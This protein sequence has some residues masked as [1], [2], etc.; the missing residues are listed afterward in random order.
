MGGVTGTVVF[1]LI[2]WTVLF[3][4]LPWGVQPDSDASET[5]G[6]WRGAPRRPGLLRKAL[7]TTA[8]SA[9]IWIG[10]ESLVRSDW[11]SFRSGW[12]A[13]PLD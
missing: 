8:I 7:W 13:L 2:W 4:V 11:L 3:A 12:L 6:G 9:V 5:T 1:F 10:I